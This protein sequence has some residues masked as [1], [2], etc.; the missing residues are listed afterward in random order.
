MDAHHLLPRHGEHAEGIV[1]PQ[2][3]LGDEGKAPQVLERVHV[4]GMHPLL[5]PQL[6]VEGDMVVGVPQRPFE[7]VELQRLDLVPAR[8]LDRIELLLFG[9]TRMPHGNLPPGGPS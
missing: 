7:T 9:R 5:V 3:L 4:L 2:I 8:H 6:A 1:A